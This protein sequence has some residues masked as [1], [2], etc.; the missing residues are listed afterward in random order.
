MTDIDIGKLE[1]MGFISLT[2]SRF[3]FLRVSENCHDIRLI[4]D[5]S[6]IKYI[7]LYRYGFMC[8]ILFL[9]SENEFLW[10]SPGHAD[11]HLSLRDRV[12]KVG[13]VLY[14]ITVFA[15]D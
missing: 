1:K 13:H 8:L 11:Y 4:G 5:M 2:F 9:F 10:N 12:Y 14:A 7:F 3:D 6:N 15:H